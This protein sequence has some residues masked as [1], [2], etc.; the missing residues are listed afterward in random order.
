MVIYESIN[1]GKECRTAG[2]D[3]SNDISLGFI[4]IILKRDHNCLFMGWL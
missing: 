3:L 1:L 4:L 2:F